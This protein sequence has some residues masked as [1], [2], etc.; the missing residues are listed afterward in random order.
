[1]R[2]RALPT[3]WCGGSGDILFSTIYFM[4]FDKPAAGKFDGSGH[5]Y[6]VVAARYNGDLME[7]LL[8]R[9]LA[10]LREA[11]VAEERID[12]L[13]VPGSNELPYGIQLGIDTGSYDCCIGLGVLIRGDTIHYQLIA[14]S[15]SDALQMVALNHTVPVVNGVVVAEN[16]AQA[17]ARITGGLNRGAEFAACALQLATLRRERENNK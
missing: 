13:R 3:S 17:E 2:V 15:V 14:Q 9:A 8:D 11:G 12:V 16:R 4:S 1:M 5:S 7:A 10:R 6:L